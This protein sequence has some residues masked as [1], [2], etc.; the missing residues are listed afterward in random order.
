MFALCFR[1]FVSIRL[2]PTLRLLEGNT[3]R[4]LSSGGDDRRGLGG[5]GLLLLGSNDGGSNLSGL[6]RLDSLLLLLLLGLVLSLLLGDSLGGGRGLLLLLLDLVGLALA[7]D[8]GAELGEG[9]RGL[10]LLALLVRGSRLLLLA[11]AEG[12]RALALVALNGRSG[13][14]VGLGRSSSNLSGLSGNVGRGR[15]LSREGLSG[16]NGGDHRGSLGNG[17]GGN[18]GLLD[19]SLS[20]RSSLLLAEGEAAKDAGALGRGSR[21]GLSDLLLLLLSLLLGLGLS[22]RSLGGGRGSLGG[23]LSNGG[24]L[25]SGSNLSSRSL[26]GSG[27]LGSGRLLSS[28]SRSLSS[29]LGG[30]LLL[31]LA[32]EAAEDGSALTAGGATLGFLL[33]DLLVLLL[34]LDLL[35]GGL[36]GSGLNRSLGNGGGGLLS[37]G[38]RG[39][40]SGGLSSL[41][42][43]LD[44]G[45]LEALNGLLVGLRF[46]DSGGKLLGLGNLGLQLGNPVVT[47]SGSGGLEGVLVALGREVELVGAI[48]NGLS[49]L[50]L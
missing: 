7:L 45:R 18:R 1:G 10:D 21:A 28:G 38:S 22:G 23:G 35:L 49:S 47:V 34:F 42:L 27:G 33:L 3:P 19:G 29:R 13:L 30:L 15:D 32:E 5:L 36:D 40:L 24:S 44:R 37:G 41:F 20:N 4:S 8:G 11:E 17:L 43:L 12:E 14:A 48:D 9:R 31:L 25:D 16:L 2:S 26:G 46:G 50:G 39:N 6:G